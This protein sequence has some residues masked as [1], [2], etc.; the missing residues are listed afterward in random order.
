MGCGTVLGYA[1]LILFAIGL[2]TIELSEKLNKNSTNNNS[3]PTEEIKK[4]GYQWSYVQANDHMSD[5]VIYQAAVKSS[6][7][8]NL[9]FPYN[10]S[11]HAILTLRSHPRHGEEVIF[12]IEKGQ[13]LCGSY[14]K[15]NILV[16]F[17]D[18]KAES[19]IGV[20]P[21]DNSTET[22]FIKNHSKFVKSMLASKLVRISLD[23]YQ[24][25]TQVFDFHVNDFNHESYKPKPLQD[26]KK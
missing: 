6:N 8:V 18:K 1:I 25:G 15:C 20:P 5:G 21:S 9:D 23:I 22:V 11:Q 13:V 10:G 7:Q 14:D 3:Q 19:F 16:R 26:S 2:F 17:D 24:N 12:R 4:P